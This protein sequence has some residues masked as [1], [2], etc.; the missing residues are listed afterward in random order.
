MHPLPLRLDKVAQLGE[1]GPQ[2]GNS[3]GRSMLQLLGHLHE[4]QAA[5]LLYMC[6]HSLDSSQ[7]CSLIGGS[8]S[9]SH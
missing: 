2:V 7:T 6:R 4:D 5:H 1:Q 9:G 3:Q 8:V